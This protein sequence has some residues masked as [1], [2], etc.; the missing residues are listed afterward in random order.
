MRPIYIFLILYTTL[1]GFDFCPEPTFIDEFED[2]NVSKN[3]VISNGFSF[4]GSASLFSS[5]NVKAEGGY[6]ILS[7]NYVSTTDDKGKKY[8]ATSGGVKSKLAFGYGKYEFRVQTRGL[9]GVREGLEISWD[10][11]DYFKHH[12]TIGYSFQK[13]GYLTMLVTG[14]GKKNEFYVYHMTNMDPVTHQP[15]AL[16]LQPHIW[17]IDYL[18]D[19]IT[20]YFDEEPIRKEVADVKN[21]P[22]HKMNVAFNNWLADEAKYSV[23]ADNM[24]IELTVD[25]FKFTP[26]NMDENSCKPIK[27][28]EEN[29]SNNSLSPQLAELKTYIDALPKGKNYL[30]GFSEE[31][32]NLKVFENV[33]VVWIYSDDQWKGYSPNSKILKAL[34]IYKIPIFNSI[35]KYTGFWIQK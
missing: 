30:V 16:N 31:I 8:L 26:L 13:T 12:E 3:W 1:F 35:P 28:I 34:V 2:G 14:V 10:G 22:T 15:E 6:L 25:Y 32:T 17:T 18:P 23:S 33:K 5:D 29:E 19:S 20:W 9:K 11:G 27:S 7:L 21:L 4:G 24:P